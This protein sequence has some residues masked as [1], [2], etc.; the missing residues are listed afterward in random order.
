MKTDD[1]PAPLAQAGVE[2]STERERFLAAVAAGAAD[3]EAGR[4]MTTAE[5][6]RRLFGRRGRRSRSP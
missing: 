1:R 3:I 2:Q 6:E 4:V 5:L